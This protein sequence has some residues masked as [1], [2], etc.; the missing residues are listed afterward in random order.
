M[1]QKKEK[2]NVML[3]GLRVVFILCW[4]DWM[5]GGKGRDG[6]GIEL[7]VLCLLKYL[8]EESEGKLIL[9]SILMFKNL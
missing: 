4:D 5:K 8:D 6:I 2:Q 1:K 3:R 7:N 9:K